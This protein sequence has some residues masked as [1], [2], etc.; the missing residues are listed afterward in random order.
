MEVGTAGSRCPEGLSPRGNV[1]GAGEGTRTPTGL[2]PPGPKPGAST[3]SA[4]PASIIR[5]NGESSV[6]GYRVVSIAV[7][8]PGLGEFNRRRPT[9]C[10]VA[11]PRAS[12]LVRLWT[13]PQLRMWV[14]GCTVHRAL[15]STRRWYLEPPNGKRGGTHDVDLGPVACSCRPTPIRGV[16]D[17]ENHDT[18]HDWDHRLWRSYWSHYRG[19][20]LPLSPTMGCS[21]SV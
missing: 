8:R 1:H 11:T 13:C 6:H 15:T 7:G 17:V 2:C 16:P 12:W 19:W 5:S 18:E 14:E 9:R 21:T 10:S 20:R 3:N 4:T